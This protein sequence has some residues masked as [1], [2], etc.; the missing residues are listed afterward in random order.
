M[1]RPSVDDVLDETRGAETTLIVG[2]LRVPVILTRVDRQPG[3][4]ISLEGHF[5]TNG[6][7]YRK[8]DGNHGAPRCG[9]PECWQR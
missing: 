8:C 1:K 9:D 5:I 2:S 7:P 6:L 3:R 4:L